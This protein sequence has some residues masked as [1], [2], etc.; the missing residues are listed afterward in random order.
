MLHD[1]EAIV[2]AVIGPGA[3]DY[4]I[5]RGMRVFNGPGVVEEVLNT[6]IDKKLLET[7]ASEEP[8]AE[9]VIR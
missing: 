5:N 4:L 2:V 7:T 3:A 1:C 9:G 6:I 8:P